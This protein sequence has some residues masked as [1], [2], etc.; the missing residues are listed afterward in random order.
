MMYGDMDGWWMVWGAIMMIVF[1]GGVVALAIW[2]VRS[3]VDRDEG[4]NDALRIAE[5]RY[6]S[7]EISPEQFERIRQDLSGRGRSSAGA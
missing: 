2:V 1:W 3:F 7:G 5:R 6:A 4:A